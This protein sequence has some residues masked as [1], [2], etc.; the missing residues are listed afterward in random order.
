MNARDTNKRVRL[1]IVAVARF[2]R[3]QNEMHAKNEMYGEKNIYFISLDAC[4]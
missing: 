1:A 4:M 2:K 3:T